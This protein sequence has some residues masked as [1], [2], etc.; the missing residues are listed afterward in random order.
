MNSIL[1]T[2]P[3]EPP[4]LDEIVLGP[5]PVSQPTDLRSRWPLAAMVD[6]A[7]AWHQRA[8]GHGGSAPRPGSGAGHVA[9]PTKCGAR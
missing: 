9:Q 4:S 5:R 7:R 8:A 3:P 1:D 6:A 2:L